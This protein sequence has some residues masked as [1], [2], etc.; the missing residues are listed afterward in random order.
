MSKGIMLPPFL[1]KKL[2]LSR[3]IVN[4]AW[5]ECGYKLGEISVSESENVVRELERTGFIIPT[6]PV[7]PARRGPRV[8]IGQG[9]A[10]VKGIR[11]YSLDISNIAYLAT[12]GGNISGYLDKLILE[13]RKRT[14]DIKEEEATP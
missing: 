6:P 4:K 9:L 7:T 12:V 11:T 14:G 1:A 8:A 3:D 5:L 10:G 13:E 2:G